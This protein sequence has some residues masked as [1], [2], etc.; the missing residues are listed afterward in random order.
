MLKSSQPT[1]PDERKRFIREQMTARDAAQQA[2]R[3][4]AAA[5]LLDPAIRAAKLANLDTAPLIATRHRLHELL[6]DAV[7]QSHGPIAPRSRRATQKQWRKEGP[8]Q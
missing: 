6:A 4:E 3:L 1:D 8:P 5:M 2:A 7:S